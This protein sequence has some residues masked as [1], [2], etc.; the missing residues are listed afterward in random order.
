MLVRPGEVAVVVESG[1]VLAVRADGRR[2]RSLGRV[3]RWD[4]GQVDAVHV[5]PDGRQV[6]VSVLDDADEAGP[7]DAAGAPTNACRA[8]VYRLVPGRPPERLL[9]GAS[10]S[11]A[12]DGRRVAYLRYT[13]Q[14]SFCVRSRLV[15]RDLVAGTEQ[16]V[17][18]PGGSALEG[19]P[20]EWPLDW[21]PDG[22]RIAFVS[23]RG[24]LVTEVDGWRTTVLGGDHPADD[25][26]LAPVFLADGTEAA[27]TGCCIGGEGRMTAYP[28]TADPHLLFAVATP[29]TS[30]RRD[31]GGNGLWL[32]M[33]ETGLWHWH[34]A[35]LRPVLAHAVQDTGPTAL[36]T[37][38]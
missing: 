36:V 5:S 37:S 2:T 26:R 10:A 3:P 4:T 1:E 11:I 30:V 14:Q 38:G 15:V 34:G 18:L 7:P 24:A 28:A 8:A 20:P 21:S 33:Q 16:A 35:R 25:R 12:P 31:R 23:E 19:T 29:V 32:T 9:D 22:K 17:G 27:M 6:L 13:R